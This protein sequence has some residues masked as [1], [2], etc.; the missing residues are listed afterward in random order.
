ALDAALLV[1]AGDRDGARLVAIVSG[2]AQQGGME[3]D[4]RAMP[5]KHGALQIVL[6]EDTRNPLPR[7]EGA[8]MAAQEALHSGVREE[9][10]KDLARVAQHHPERHQRP[11]RPADL[12]VAE[13]SPLCREPDYAELLGAVPSS[14]QPLRDSLQCPRHSPCLSQSALTK[15]SIASGGLYTPGVP[16]WAVVLASIFSFMARSASK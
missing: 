6:E 8:D 14:P 3:A 1:A 4:R 9:A 16:S 7:G 2:E 5:L 12:K 15:A 11:P 10:Q 13:V